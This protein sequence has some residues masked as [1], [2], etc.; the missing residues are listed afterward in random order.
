MSDSNQ[1]GYYGKARSG[2]SLS[3]FGAVSF[4]VNQVLDGRNTATLVQVKAVSNTGGLFPVGLVDVL[5]LVNQLDGEG[6]AVPHQVVRR[7][8]YF[9]LQGG[10]NAVI[11]D[12]QVGDIGI[13]VFADRDIS[14]VKAAKA[15]ANPGSARR[16]NKA[17]GLYLGGFLNG[18]PSQYVQFSAAGIKLHSPAAVIL[19][20][21]D[22]QISAATVEIAATTS[23]T[24]TTPSFTVNGAT[25]LNGPLNQ[26]TGSGGGGATMLGPVTVTNDVTAGG[27][28]LKT[29]VHSGVTT[30]GGNTGS[31][32]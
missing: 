32:V 29:H 14:S 2:D 15:Q 18:T 21:P 28:S 11:I 12:P 6:N 3:D 27:K 1:D 16:S 5:P 22:V 17:D 19:E 13:A 10:A 24:I 8:P 26:G 23:T 4:L 7:L 25:T 30:G 20:A 9:R 31:P